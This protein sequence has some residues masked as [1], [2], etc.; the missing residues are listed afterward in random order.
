ML[1]PQI[2]STRKIGLGKRTWRET[3]VI[4]SCGNWNRTYAASGVFF[5]AK[6]AEILRT[7]TN[8]ARKW[9]D[10]RALAILWCRSRPKRFPAPTRALLRRTN[11]PMRAI[12]LARGA[13]SAR[14]F[15]VRIRAPA[16]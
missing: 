2:Y 8:W 5:I 14:T 12:Q 9:S 3:E 13:L 15:A 16:I 11:L 6:V 1:P 10:V 7:P 4:W